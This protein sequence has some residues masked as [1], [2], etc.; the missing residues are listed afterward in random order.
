M[1]A[2]IVIKNGGSSNEERGADLVRRHDVGKE[3]EKRP[4]LPVTYILFAR[5]ATAGLLR[6]LFV[7]CECKV[8]GV[9]LFSTIRVELKVMVI[10]IITTITESERSVRPHV[11]KACH[12]GDK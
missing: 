7:S 9:F 12:K 2:G 3:A 5:V 1:W 11:L 8:G 6:L 4:L 10:K